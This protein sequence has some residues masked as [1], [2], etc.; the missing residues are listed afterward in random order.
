MSLTDYSHK[1]PNC[2]AEGVENLIV[3]QKGYHIIPIILHLLF[4]TVREANKLSEFL[5]CRAIIL[6][7]ERSSAHTLSLQEN[8]NLIII[9]MQKI[10]E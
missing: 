5:F 9:S 8:R 4:S 7:I 3:L 2:G 6:Q 1:L 10:L